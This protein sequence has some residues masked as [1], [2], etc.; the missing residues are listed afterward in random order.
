MPGIGI[1]GLGVITWT[2]VDLAAG[3]NLDGEFCGVMKL[4]TSVGGTPPL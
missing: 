1:D 2:G 3:I 4:A